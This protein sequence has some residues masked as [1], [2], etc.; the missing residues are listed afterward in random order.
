VARSWG[1][2]VVRD[3]AGPSGWVDCHDIDRE[4]TNPSARFHPSAGLFWRPGE[5]PM[6]LFD[7]GVARG[8][9]ST[10]RDCCADLASIYLFIPKGGGAS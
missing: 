9:Y 10:W 1:V 2:R 3:V 4:D 7:L 6:S 8:C 5:R